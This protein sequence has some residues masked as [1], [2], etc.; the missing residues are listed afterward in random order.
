M[1][2]TIKIKSDT[3]LGY[4][5]INLDEYDQKIHKAYE[6]DLVS[7]DTKNEPVKAGSE[8]SVKKSR[9]KKSDT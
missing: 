4:M 8:V 3:E 5:V 9:S 2:E 7:D 1:L 6:I